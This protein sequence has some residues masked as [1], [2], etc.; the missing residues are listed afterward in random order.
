MFLQDVYKPE[1]IKVGL[2]AE[3]KDDV[4]EELA[5]Q[6]CQASKINAREEILAAIREREA[7]MSTG[8]RQGI[9]IPHGKTNAVDAVYGVLGVSKRGIDYDALDGKP[10]YLLFLI[11]APEKD[12]ENYLRLLKRAA[13][14]LD[15]PLFYTDLVAQNSAQEAYN[16]LK[17]YE[18]ILI[19]LD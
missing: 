11:L 8:I 15:N 2:E 13:E 16:I 1:F 4:F 10:V 5:D 14:L 3:D 9:A 12:T 18:D 6:F 19:A 7:K 17:K